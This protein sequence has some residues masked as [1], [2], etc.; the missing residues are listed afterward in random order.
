MSGMN[1]LS[2]LAVDSGGKANVRAGGDQGLWLNGPNNES[3]RNYVVRKRNQR[4]ACSSTCDAV[5][6][7]NY[8]MWQALISQRKNNTN[9]YDNL[10][11]GFSPLL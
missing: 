2:F 1:A 7:R 3:N 8:K 5:P 9:I 11:I 4:F 6:L 10:Y